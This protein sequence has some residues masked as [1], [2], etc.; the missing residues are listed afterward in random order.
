MLER[1][2]GIVEL[3]LH[4]LADVHHRDVRAATVLRELGVHH[5]AVVVHHERGLPVFAQDDVGRISQPCPVE[6]P[7]IDQGPA[8]D[9]VRRVVVLRLEGLIQVDRVDPR[10]P[11]AGGQHEPLLRLGEIGRKEDHTERRE[12]QPSRLAHG[13]LSAGREIE[14]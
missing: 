4:H 1:R 12:L 8:D 3:A 11:A 5:A 10:V 6:P 14:G 13:N 2:I 7:G 9:R